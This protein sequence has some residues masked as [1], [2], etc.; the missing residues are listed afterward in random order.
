VNILAVTIS[1]ILT[2]NHHVTALVEKSYVT[3]ATLVAQLLYA[4]LLVQ[5]GGG[6]KPS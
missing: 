1:D 2:F 4:R 6:N 3:L 5:L